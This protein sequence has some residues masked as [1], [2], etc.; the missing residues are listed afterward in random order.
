MPLVKGARY[1]EQEVIVVIQ[2]M[3]PR[4]DLAALGAAHNRQASRFAAAS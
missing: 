4:V 3:T 1:S 2:R